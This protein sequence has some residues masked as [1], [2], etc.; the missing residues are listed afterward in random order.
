MILNDG[1]VDADTDI[2]T[3]WGYEEDKN[4]FGF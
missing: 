2:T 4:M 3:D 1:V